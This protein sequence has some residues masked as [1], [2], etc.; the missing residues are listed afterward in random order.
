MHKGAGNSA[1]V[2]FYFAECRQSC[3]CCQKRIYRGL[4]FKKYLSLYQV[5]LFE[6]E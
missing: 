2:L 1:F 5:K 4:H 6:N 3:I